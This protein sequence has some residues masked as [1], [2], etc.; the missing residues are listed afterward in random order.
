M[1]KKKHSLHLSSKKIKTGQFFL[2]CVFDVIAA[3][4]KGVSTSN[5]I[6]GSDQDKNDSKS[7][8][9]LGSAS[10][11]AATVVPEK[12]RSQLLSEFTAYRVKELDVVK[13]SLIA[14]RDA[15]E[16]VKAQ[17]TRAAEILGETAFNLSF[18]FS[19]VE[20]LFFKTALAKLDS[21]KE[22]MQRWK[23][24]RSIPASAIFLFLVVR[25]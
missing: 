11:A 10:T 16:Q 15:A 19:L 14:S 1:Q 7:I 8:D 9:I 12:L 17:E 24:G 2:R 5:D 25:Q 23:V 4:Q 21:A 13:A 22:K 3:L 20:C 18:V 6:A